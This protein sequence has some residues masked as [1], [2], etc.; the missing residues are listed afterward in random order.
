MTI[1][2]LPSCSVWQCLQSVFCE[3]GR[4]PCKPVLLLMS[5]RM[6][7]WSWQ[8]MQSLP[9]RSLLDVSWHL[10]HCCSNFSWA[11]ITGPGINNDFRFSALLSAA[12]NV[13]DIVRM[14][15]IQACICN[16]MLCNQ[17]RSLSVHVDCK[18]MND[19][20]D[21]HHN[22]QRHMEDMPQRKQPFIDTE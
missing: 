9:C 22:E 6:F 2:S 19:C 20:G 14:S 18:N 1:A 8:C 11:L 16:C 13:I 10:S 4:R 7:S 15:R 17:A 12:K 21:N 3:A 5:S